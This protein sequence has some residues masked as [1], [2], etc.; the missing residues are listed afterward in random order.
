MNRPK[1]SLSPCTCFGRGDMRFQEA[2]L[3]AVQR[4]ETDKVRYCPLFSLFSY[5]RLSDGCAQSLYHL[6]HTKIASIPS[7]IA[8]AHLSHRPAHQLV[9]RQYSMFP[10]QIDFTAEHLLTHPLNALEMDFEPENPPPH[11]MFDPATETVV[12]SDRPKIRK[13]D[14]EVA[15]PGRGGYTLASDLKWPDGLYGKVQV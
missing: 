13:P 12:L 15:R 4:P 5:C 1:V 2:I 10:L 9:R 7:R 8:M 11:R 14:G 6:V 3:Q